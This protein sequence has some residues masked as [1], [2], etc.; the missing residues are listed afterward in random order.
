MLL[1]ALEK[2]ELASVAGYLT[3]DLG[4]SVDAMPADLTNEA[5]R[6][7][8]LDWLSAAK[9]PPDILINNAGGGSF[10]RFG[11]SVPG[12]IERTLDLVQGGIEVE[13][14]RHGSFRFVRSLRR[15]D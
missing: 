9:Q 6:M 13:S 5:D 7:R 11:S 4:A 1:T 12:D 3:A 8:F 14:F 2:D 15:K 10:G